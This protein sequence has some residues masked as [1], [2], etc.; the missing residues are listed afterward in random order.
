MPTTT[1]KNAAPNPPAEVLAQCIGERWKNYLLAR[2]Q[3]M[4]GN[5]K[6]VHDMRVSLRRLLTALDVLRNIISASEIAPTYAKLKKQLG[7]LGKFRDVQVQNQIVEKLLP[8]FP[9]LEQ[10]SDKLSGVE[11]RL[12]A[13]IPRI[14][15]KADAD[16]IGDTLI[17]LEGTLIGVFSSPES[18]LR[19]QRLLVQTANDAFTAV[20]A[21][22][23]KLDA[24]KPES[25]HAARLAF[26]RLRY[27]ME[28]FMPLFPAI[29]ETRIAEART[30]Q[31]LMGRF[32]DT[33]TLIDAMKQYRW[34]GRKAKKD[35]AR[36]KK[37]LKKR[38]ETTM[39]DIV[40]KMKEIESLW[41]VTA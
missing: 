27:L 21:R 38:Y 4:R 16:A 36:A 37:M 6:A 20:L 23:A 30:L 24:S 33:E 32:H 12:G 34:K 11:N 7:K 39:R 18:E 26:K 35:Y 31:G 22:R 40:E 25:V 19:L 17:G 15:A 28:L 2:E 14:A 41:T 8:E 5:T 1:L 13:K 9:A 3:C 29:T 10:F